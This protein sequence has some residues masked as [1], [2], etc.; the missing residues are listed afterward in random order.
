MNATTKQ[1]ENEL[2]R[3]LPP[4]D[5]ERQA[6]EVAKAEQDNLEHPEAMSAYF[7]MSE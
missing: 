1:Q 2:R 7:R 4:L 5:Q 3:L 6:E